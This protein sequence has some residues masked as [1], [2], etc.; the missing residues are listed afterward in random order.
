MRNFSVAKAQRP[1]ETLC[2]QENSI[3]KKYFPYLEQLPNLRCLITDS[4]ELRHLDKYPKLFQ[5][6]KNTYHLMNAQVHRESLFNNIFHQFETAVGVLWSIR[7]DLYEKVA[8]GTFV[9]ET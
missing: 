7:K 8:L 4:D 9:G 2:I 6:C 1:L 3:L 5:A